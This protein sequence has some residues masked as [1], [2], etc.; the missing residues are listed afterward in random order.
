MQ[1]P[2]V[3]LSKEN[4]KITLWRIKLLHNCNVCCYAIVI[5]CKPTETLIEHKT[6]K[7][8]T[9]NAGCHVKIPTAINFLSVI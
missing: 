7:Q 6:N 9:K 2:D 4:V 3:I 8:T 1:T 5:K